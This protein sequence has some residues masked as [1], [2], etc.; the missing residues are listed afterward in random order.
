M[1][2]F[3]QLNENNEVIN[4]IVVGNDDCLDE[5]GQESEQKGIEFCKSILGPNTK[6]VQTSYNNN[7]RVRYAGIGMT[8]DKTLDAFIPPKPYN[9][10]VLNNTT[11]SW[12][13]P[14]PMPSDAPEG[15]YYQWNEDNVN[16]E[17]ITPEN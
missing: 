1:A 11:A 16:W 4:V 2:H 9:S 5:N 15:S 10:W 3:A 14:V 8:Y 7:I 12:E 17:L 6:W 13:A